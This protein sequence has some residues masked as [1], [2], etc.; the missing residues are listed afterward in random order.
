[1]K[2]NKKEYGKGFESGSFTIE[3]SWISSFSKNSWNLYIN[4]Q[5][6]A[7][8]KTAGSCKRVAQSIN[9]EFSVTKETLVY[10]EDK[11]N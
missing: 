1:M 5:F 11:K 3:P 4:G 8:F 10:K 7:S 9:R 6:L 2:W